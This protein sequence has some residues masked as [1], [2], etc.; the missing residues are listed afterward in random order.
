M[1]NKILSIIMVLVLLSTYSMSAQA[2]VISYKKYK[3]FKYT[4]PAYNEISIK[5]Y[6]GKKIKAVVPEKIK[7]IKVTCV[8][9]VR[10]KN[11]KQIKL[12]RYV[13]DAC[14]SK[15]KAL[16]K[17]TLSKKN[18][19][20]SVKNNMVLNKKK[21][22]LISVLGGYDEIKTPQCVKIV[23]NCSFYESKV[24]KV[25]IT[26]NV[27]KLC[28]AFVGCRKLEDVV[29]E[30]NSIPNIEDG[31]FWSDINFHVKSKK[32][33]DELI[34]EMEGMQNVNAHIYVDNELVIEKKLERV[35]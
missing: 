22:K 11:L 19:Y 7:G 3:D 17:V 13:K 1:K 29:F 9:L 5:I 27:K 25:T 23:G 34:K 8:N 16:K 12:S 31:T 30:G 24:K 14:L 18:K 32:I 10:A 20:L 4:K 33:A 26:K 35:Y 6:N 21:T 28:T 15:N 2:E